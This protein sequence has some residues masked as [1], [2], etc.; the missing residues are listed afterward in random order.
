M[1]IG[2]RFDR[3]DRMISEGRVIRGQW[4]DGKERACLLVAISPEAGEK[5]SVSA[6]PVSLIPEWL[7][8]LTPSMD[9]NGSQ[10]AWPAFIKRYASVVRRASK[11][12]DSPTWRRVEYRVKILSVQKAMSHTTD[13]AVLAACKTV[14]DLCSNV[15]NNSEPSSD[16]WSAARSAAWDRLN[17]QILNA[18]ETELK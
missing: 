15:I 2:S 7:A 1:N 10:E 14:I 9:D 18:I 17:T 11:S 13:A 4:T 16:E 3:L 12:L 5:Q 8:H 6:C